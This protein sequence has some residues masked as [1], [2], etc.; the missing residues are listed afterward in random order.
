M[1]IYNLYI[2]FSIIK[3]NIIYGFKVGNNKLT[4]FRKEGSAVKQYQIVYDNFEKMQHFIYS[5][6]IN[7]SDNVLIQIFTAVIE[8]K[9]IKDLTD[10]ITSILP[11]AEIIG[12]TTAGEIYEG[13]VLSKTTIISFSIFEKVRI[14]AKLLS[15]KNEYKLGVNIVKELSEDYTKAIILFSD[16]LITNGY[17]IIKGIESANSKIIICGGKAGDNGYLKK[18]FVFTKEGITENGVAAASLSGK[19]LNITTERSFSWSPIGKLMTVTKALNNRIFTIDN[20]KT[21]DVYKKYLGDEVT[22]DLPMS[23]TEFPLI[24]RRNGTYLARVAFGRHDD[25]SLSFLGDVKVNDKVQFGYGDVNVITSQALEM[26]NRLKNRNIEAIFVYSCSVRKNFMQNKI[27]IETSAVNNIA[28]TFGFFTYGEFFTFNRSNELLN[29]TMTILGI[30]E[31]NQTSYKNV[32]MPNN[33]NENSSKSFFEGKDVG[34]IKVFTNL[35]NQ[36]TKELQEANN[37]LEKQKYKVEQMNNATKAIMEINSHMLSSCEIDSLFEMILCKALDIIS[38][39]TMGSILFMRNDKLVYKATK[40]YFTDKI[41]EIGYKLK[42]LYQYKVH[43]MNIKELRNPIVINNL[44]EN[45]FNE[46]YKYNSWK[47][48]LVKC[49]YELLTCGICIDGCVKGFINIFNTDEKKSF[50][51]DDKKLLKYL[52]YDI[53]IAFKNAQ[54]LENILYMSRYD[55]LTK[56]Y[57]RSYFNK[58]L[59]EILHKAR[60]S[61]NIFAICI[62]DLNNLKVI[63]DTYGHIMGD[64]VLTKFANIFKKEICEEDIFARIGG[65]EFAVVFVNKDEN[66]VTDIISRVSQIL[67]DYPFDLDGNKKEIS[68]AYGFS[69]FRR[70]S[71][72]IEELMK[73]SD[74]RMYEKKKRMKD[75]RKI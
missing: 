5:N 60:I 48:L 46:K 2:L 31:G 1:R 39:G 3:I 50:N 16:G 47:K 24:I 64:E 13:N 38:S 71:D 7:N 62:I 44:E 18:T 22:K 73:L 51:E 63:N 52:S 32:T 68:F 11:K 25:G 34:V 35:V 57:N 33:E 26:T 30:S 75:R 40:G 14:K 19:S 43:D 6:N 17:Q 4:L 28:P 72:D 55:S 10:K 15:D 59:G 9:F 21:I 58:L 37:V 12:A 70:D 42:D 66:S 53:A 41:K 56:I 8:M 74:K 36:V 54:L 61:S 69:Q 65:D 27:G 23:A 20:I 49:P 45:L 29:T 67:K